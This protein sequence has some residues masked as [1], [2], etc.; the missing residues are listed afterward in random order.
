MWFLEIR[1]AACFRASL[2]EDPGEYGSGDHRIQA[3][4]YRMCLTDVPENR[5]EIT[6]PEGYDS[7]QYELL[8]RVFDAGWRR[9]SINLIPYQTE[10]PM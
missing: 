7:T 2:A 9:L 8:V 10:R 5:V 3:Y 4:C 1:P 6:R